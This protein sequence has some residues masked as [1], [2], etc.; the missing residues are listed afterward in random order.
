MSLRTVLAAAVVLA[1]TTSFVVAEDDP[2]HCYTTTDPRCSG[3]SCSNTFSN[4]AAS[5]NWQQ[6]R[7]AA[8]PQV[9]Q[10]VAGVY[11]GEIP[12]PSGQMTNR[13][14]RSYESNGLW[15][16]QDQTCTPGLGCSQ[17]QGAGQ[18]AG[19][20]L[21]DGSVFLMIHFSDLVR[22][23]TCFSQTIQPANG[24]FFEGAMNWQRTR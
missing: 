15:Q 23:N 6:T 4:P 14:Y 22:S 8:D 7:Q 17:N 2:D 11:Y 21:A 18:W 16:Y 9:M 12:D 20:R 3:L 5:L 1:A 24:G 13:T 10:E 19:Y